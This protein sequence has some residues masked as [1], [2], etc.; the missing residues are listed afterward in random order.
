MVA[1][2]LDIAIVVLLLIT[3]GGGFRLHGALKTFRVES[4]EIQPIIGALDKAAGR[5]EAALGSLRQ[6]VDDVGAR[7]GEETATGQ[8]LLDELDFMTKRA[9]QLAE[10]LD[11]GIARARS[12]G[13]RSQSPKAGS[14]AEPQPVKAARTE[15]RR[16]PPDLEQ[17]LK[18]LR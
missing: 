10:R 12:A 9:D 14:A 2:T 6:M 18:N 8:R 16:R 17:R 5:A 13:S 3:L 1:L 7:M 11:D 4:N 15:P